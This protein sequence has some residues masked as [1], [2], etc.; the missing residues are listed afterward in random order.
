[1]KKILDLQLLKG[2][3]VLRYGLI[4]IMIVVITIT[5]INVIVTTTLTFVHGLAH[6]NMWYYHIL[7]LGGLGFGV[8]TLNEEWRSSQ[9]IGVLVLVCVCSLT[10]DSWTACW[11]RIRK[12]NLQKHRACYR[13]DVVF[14]YQSGPRPV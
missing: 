11:T 9:I 6:G 12:L 8:Q 1:M 13:V 10:A 14:D 4:M 3:R 5:N 7:S 2:S